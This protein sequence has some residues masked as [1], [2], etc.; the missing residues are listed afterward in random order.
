M[1]DAAYT[2]A[3]HGTEYQNTSSQTHALRVRSSRSFINR[4]KDV[5]AWGNLAC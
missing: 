5:K 2:A 1:A 4:F 3:A